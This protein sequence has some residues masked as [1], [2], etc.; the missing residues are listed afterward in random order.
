MIAE[1]WDLKTYQVGNFPPN[2][3]EW[4]GK[5]RDTARSFLRGDALQAREMA[6]R[7]TGSADLYGTYRKPFNSINFI[8]C[9]DG[10]TLRDLYTYNIKHNEANKEDNK[11]GFNDNRSWNCGFEGETDDLTINNLRAKMIKNALCMLILSAGTPMLLYGD[12]VKRTQK[13]NNNAYCQDNDITWFNWNDFETHK[14]NFEFCRKL[15]TLRK[16]YP[17]FRR[18]YFFVNGTEE[19]KTAPE[20]IWFGRHLDPP[21]WDSHS[22]KTVFYQLAG[23]ANSLA[24]GNYYLFLIFNMR[25]ICTTV[26]LP[27]H[28]GLK[29]YRMIDTSRQAGEDFRSHN[30]EKMLRNQ[31]EH[32]ASARCINVLLA[33]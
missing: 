22:L 25:H 11:D 26:H 33:K 28:E 19:G 7:L 9:H 13:G 1:P 23:S 31:L 21:N 10:F 32:R 6:K 29:W 2:W 27:Q 24:S 14:E 16:H 15:I 12:E 18:T 17:F 20:I 8:T 4:N 30:K 3:S 5:Y